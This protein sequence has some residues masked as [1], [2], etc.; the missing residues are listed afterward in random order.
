MQQQCCLRKL[1]VCRHAQER[2]RKPPAGSWR[3]LS[4]PALCLPRKLLESGE[5]DVRVSALRGTPSRPPGYHEGPL[6]RTRWSARTLPRK[7]L[8][9]VSGMRLR[10][11]HLPWKPL[12]FSLLALVVHVSSVQKD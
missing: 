4:V 1:S 11:R 7:P 12:G 10:A 9:T 3:S 2:D 8:K 5:V 6:A